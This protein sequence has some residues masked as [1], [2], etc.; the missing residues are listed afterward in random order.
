MSPI[1]LKIKPVSHNIWEGRKLVEAAHKYNRCVQGGTQWNSDGRMRKA[2]GLIHEGMIGDLYM[3]RA[4][5]NGARES[6]GFKQLEDP[7][8][9]LRW[10]LWLGPA[11]N[12]PFHRSLVHYNWHW[13][14]DF[15]NGEMGNNG[16]HSLNLARWALRKGLPSKI[17]SVGGRFGYKDQAQ[18]PN[19]QTT[20]FEYEDGTVLVGEIRGLYTAEEKDS[21]WH[22]YGT[23]GYMHI[24]SHLEYEIYLGRSSKPEPN[25]GKL[26]DIDYYGNFV[27]VMRAGK[28]DMLTAEIEQLHLS[29]TL[30]HLGNISYRLKRKLY[31][32]PEAERFVGDAEADSLLRREYRKPYTVSENI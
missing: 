12:Q 19:T 6:I 28:P 17:H 5:L 9:W 11:Q 30:C 29:C 23:K 1:A 22:F 2:I 8:S 27:D 15:G 16:S 25:P 32:D 10:D 4:V 31:F 26:D 20:T 14:W 13:F 24:N 18:T 21:S 3:V 7:P